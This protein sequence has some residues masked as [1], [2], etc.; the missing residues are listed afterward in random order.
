[1]FS[2][3]FPLE[4]L[5]KLRSKIKESAGSLE[6]NVIFSSSESLVFVLVSWKEASFSKH[7]MS[8]VDG[9][10]T[11]NVVSALISFFIFKENKVTFELI[12]INKV[13]YK[14]FTKFDFFIADSSILSKLSSCF[15]FIASD[16][17]LT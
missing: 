1:M 5:S 2:S 12:Y 17:S 9:E 4:F 13:E 6:S 15:L 3:F 16:L 10:S 7:R 11:R 8:A 14:L